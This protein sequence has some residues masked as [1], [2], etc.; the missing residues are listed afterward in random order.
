LICKL[1]RLDMQERVLF[2]LVYK[3]EDKS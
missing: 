3:K 2:K 1:V